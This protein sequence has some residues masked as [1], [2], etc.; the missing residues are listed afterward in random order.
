MSRRDEKP[1]IVVL[2][3]NAVLDWAV[4]REPAFAALSAAIDAGHLRWVG[5]AR[6]RNELAHVLA[7]GHLAAYQ[8]DSLPVLDLW[9]RYCV[10]LPEPAGTAGRLRCSDPDDQ[11]FI[12]L[13]VAVS[14]QWLISRDRAVLKLAKRLR[15]LDI[16]VATPDGWR[17]GVRS[18]RSSA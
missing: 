9:D 12:D 11:M 2:D 10:L 16:I 18:G 1:P 8:S 17:T 5:T 14:G 6:M 13:V 15:E 7:R 4:F 3:T